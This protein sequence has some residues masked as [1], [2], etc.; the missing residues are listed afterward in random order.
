M[1]AR[2]TRPTVQRWTALSHT[3]H[4]HPVHARAAAAHHLHAARGDPTHYDAS[5]ATHQHTARTVGANVP[6]KRAPSPNT[7]TPKRAQS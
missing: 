4:V 5:G 3:A 6:L 1:E 7:A 2:E